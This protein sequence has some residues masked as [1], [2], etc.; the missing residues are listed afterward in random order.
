MFHA[1]VGIAGYFLP[2]AGTAIVTFCSL[3]CG[4]C[5]APMERE[6]VNA[7]KPSVSGPKPAR[8]GVFAVLLVLDQR[9]PNASTCSPS[10]RRTIQNS[11]TVSNASE[12]EVAAAAPWPPKRGTSITHSTRFMTKASA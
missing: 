8:C 1:R 5:E 6:V 3:K 2:Y 4:G 11:S 12:I 10:R 7:P 9:L